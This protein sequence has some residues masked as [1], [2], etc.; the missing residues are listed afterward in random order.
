MHNC[1]KWAKVTHIEW[2]PPKCSILAEKPICPPIQLAGQPI[3]TERQ[4]EYLGTYIRY[5]GISPAMISQR[6]IK[7]KK[8]AAA[9]A[10]IGLVKYLNVKQRDN[11]CKLLITSKW[12]YMAYIQQWTASTARAID[13]LEANAMNLV[14]VVKPDTLGRFA[15]ATGRQTVTQLVHNRI[16]KA[17]KRLEFKQASET[18]ESRECAALITR[19]EIAVLTVTSIQANATLGTEQSYNDARRAY[20]IKRSRQVPRYKDRPPYLKMKQKANQMRGL[21]WYYKAYPH[22]RHWEQ[23][24]AMYR[25]RAPAWIGRMHAVLKQAT[26]D[27]STRDEVSVLMNEYGE[28]ERRAK[29]AAETQPSTSDEED[30]HD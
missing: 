13:K 19:A 6:I 21:W 17:M 7:A 18:A 1:S 12:S 4:T 3:K 15:A 26:W 16:R 11:M 27:K 10:E 8:A 24:S 25:D 28:M 30:T 9:L 14:R 29:I 20:E 23:V 2:E 22:P 5:D